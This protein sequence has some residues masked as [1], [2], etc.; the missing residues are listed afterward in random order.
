LPAAPLLGP[1]VPVLEPPA[2]Y[3]DRLVPDEAAANTPTLGEYRPKTMY[4]PEPFFGRFTDRAEPKDE[5]NVLR[6]VE[7]FEYFAVAH[8]APPNFWV[9]L[10]RPHL[11]S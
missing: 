11:S 6:L 5:D 2:L 8:Q 7:D 9:Y 1:I 10:I 3:P 4:A